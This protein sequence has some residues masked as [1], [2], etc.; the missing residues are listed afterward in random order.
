MATLSVIVPMLNEAAALPVLCAQLES[1]AVQGIEVILVDG[2]SSDGSAD[3]A[4]QMAQHMGFAVVR[5]ARGRAVQMNGGAARA[6]G[7][8][9]LFL[10]AD[11]RLPA[12][13][14]ALLTALDA[15][16]VAW[17]RFDVTIEGRPAMLKVVAV[18]MNW[19][20]RIT[21]I[22][23]GDQAIFM[24]RKAFDAVGGFPVQPL[25]EDI[26]ITSRLR[27]LA[28]PVCLAERVT[29]SGRRWEQRGVWR[30]IVLMWR[31]RWAYWRGVPASD[32]AKAYR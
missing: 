25:M 27:R 30:T 19:R 23:T 16:A 15:Q 4:E 28:R 12:A 14:P 2:G 18:L 17:G 10:H 21:G 24:T 32:I 5:S 11:T 13:A 3:R 9:L 6:R 31:L 7:D 26:E 22:A 20:S 1:L 8:V 29:T